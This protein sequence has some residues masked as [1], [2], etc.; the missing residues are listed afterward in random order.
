MTLDKS[1]FLDIFHS[2]DSFEAIK[3]FLKK[4]D[5]FRHCN[6]EGLERSDIKLQYYREN[7]LIACDNDM[8]RKMYVIRHGSAKG[9][10]HKVLSGLELDSTSAVSETVILLLK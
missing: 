10:S 2:G 8:P 3:L 5:H 9:K 4:I 7:S 6:L 1:D